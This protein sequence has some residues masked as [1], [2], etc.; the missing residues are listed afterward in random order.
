VRIL[1]VKGEHQYRSK[2]Y[3]YDP[4]SNGTY[5]R[6]GAD[7]NYDTAEYVNLIR[8]SRAGKQ[9]NL[10]AWNIGMGLAG[11]A[12]VG[13]DT[14][15][16]VAGIKAEIDELNSSGWYDVI[17]LAGAIHGLAYVGE[18]YDP[19]AGSH[20]TASSLAD[21][22]MILAGYQL[23]SGDFIWNANYPV[24]G[25]DNE[26][27][28]ESAYAIL[29]LEKLDPST[30][31]GSIHAAGS[32]LKCVQ[33]G[34]GGWENYV[35]AGENN[36]VTGEALSGIDIASLYNPLPFAEANGPYMVAV[37]QSVALDHAGSLDPDDDPL[38]FSW[39][40]SGQALGTVSMESFTAGSEAGITEVILTVEDDWSETATDTAMMIIYDPN[41]G[42][43]TGG[44]WIDSP[45]GPYH[46]DLRFYDG[47]FYGILQL[48]EPLTRSEA[49]DM[50]AGMT[51]ADCTSAHLAT[52]TS[53][54]EYEKLLELFGGSPDT[55]RI[56]IWW[57][58]ANG[59]EYIV[60]GNG[61]NQ[62]IGG[63]SIVVKKR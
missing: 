24:E 34:T 53:Q 44:G 35:G 5:D 14:T 6:N 51:I 38:S 28:Q 17:G 63:G 59:T 46:P 50:A 19:T 36:E 15:A 52:I 29:A 10:A 30:H 13:A 42:F 57:E 32:Y 62:P 20:E 47:S 3:F 18:D 1:P 37:G 61:S 58:D 26:S 27:I 49:Q 33:L 21:L 25:E 40:V 7:T 45:A 56:R 22:G 9:A 43:V 8:T 55:F 39:T 11:A 48:E 4:L 31:F 60:Y 2:Q 16:W 12:A 41:G 54:Q 23:Q